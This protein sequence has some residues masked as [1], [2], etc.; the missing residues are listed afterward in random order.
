MNKKI[1]LIMIAVFIIAVSFNVYADEIGCCSNPAAGSWA[2]SSDLANRDAQC[3]PPQA[4]NPS[5]YKP[6]NPDGPVDYNACKNSFFA[7]GQNCRNVEACNQGC[8]CSDTGGT[9]K[10]KI[11]CTGSGEIFDESDPTCAN[12]AD[13][14]CNDGIDND[15][16]G[17]SDFQGGDYGC[18][19]TSDTSEARGTCLGQSGG[20]LDSLY[21]PK[22]SSLIITQ[23][24]GQK[25]LFL[26]WIDECGQNAV[27]YDI[28]RCK[29]QDCTNLVFV[30]TSATN[31]FEDS[32]A[33]LEYDTMYTY[34]V[35]AHY[36]PQSSTP[37]V[38]DTER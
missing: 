16:N 28:S 37:T 9:V 6:Q 2:C 34:Q 22:L 18:T 29:G 13:P 10:S 1:F 3:C 27:S 20:C 24:I 17:C 32:S 23:V 15:N 38:K 36:S 19:D 12:C 30:T 14:Q 8:C 33:E 4:A 7:V 11:Q 35:K 31:S 21:N 5:Y 25:K 26:R